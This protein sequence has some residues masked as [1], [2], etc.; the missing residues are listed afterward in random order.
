VIAYLIRRVLWGLT[1]LVVISFS[2]FAIFFVVPQDR[3]EL[4][5]GLAAVDINLREAA[6]LNSTPL[7]AQWAQYMWNAVRHQSL[8]RSFRSQEDVADIIFRALPVTMSLVFGGV[9]LFLLVA[10]PVGILSAVR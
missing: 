10:I 6:S 7:P 2:T 9:V 5:R 3:Q 4:G 1:L 8:G